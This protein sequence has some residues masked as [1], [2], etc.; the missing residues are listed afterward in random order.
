MQGIGRVESGTETESNA[1]G[2]EV[3]KKITQGQ[4]SRRNEDLNSSS[5]TNPAVNDFFLHKKSRNICG[6][7]TF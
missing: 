4:L 6:F 7:F 2:Q 5:S 3:R 1:L